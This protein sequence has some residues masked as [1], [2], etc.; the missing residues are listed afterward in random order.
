M[1]ADDFNQRLGER[2]ALRP[3]V[4]N[5]LCSYLGASAAGWL[6]NADFTV[7]SV[8]SPPLRR[9]GQLRP[10]T[11]VRAGNCTRPGRDCDPSG[12]N[13][14]ALVRQVHR[15]APHLGISRARTDAWPA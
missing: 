11:P 12:A 14:S 3:V 15:Q 13:A 7:K 1:G 8:E 6:R 5:R 2:P 10:L 9:I 4:W